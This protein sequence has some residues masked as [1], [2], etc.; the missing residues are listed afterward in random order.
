M[1]RKRSIIALT[2][3]GTSSW[4]ECS[5]PTVLPYRICGSDLLSRRV[6]RNGPGYE[7]SEG[8]GGQVR[9]P[10]AVA[11]G[12][13]A[14]QKYRPRQGE[15]TRGGLHRTHGYRGDCE[16]RAP[17][18]QAVQPHQL[19][20]VG[21]RR[22]AGRSE[23]PLPYITSHLYNPLI[24]HTRLSG[25]KPAADCFIIGNDLCYATTRPE[26]WVVYRSKGDD[27]HGKQV[28]IGGPVTQ[29]LPD[30]PRELP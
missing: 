26:C 2:C 10:V 11:F 27:G 22:A 21:F 25:R 16:R 5:D 24:A 6:R 8:S 28:Q 13:A 9:I 7:P 12:R 15:Q 20:R 3:S 30:R 19:Q 23:A 1:A 17:Q 29:R 14:V 4:Q 18:R